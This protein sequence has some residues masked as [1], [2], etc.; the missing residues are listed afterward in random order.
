[1]AQTMKKTMKKQKQKKTIDG[2]DDDPPRVM[3]SLIAFESP[4]GSCLCVRVCLCGGVTHIDNHCGMIEKVYVDVDDDVDD[5][6]MSMMCD[7]V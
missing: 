7:D 2:S 5:V 4:I 6:S 3:L 1:M